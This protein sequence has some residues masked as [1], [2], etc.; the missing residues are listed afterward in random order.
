[1][2]GR[3]CMEGAAR[4]RDGGVPT[5][6]RDGRRGSGPFAGTIMLSTQH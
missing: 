6:P 4:R 2:M 1:M 3:R 5:R